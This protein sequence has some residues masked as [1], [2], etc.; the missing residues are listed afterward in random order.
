M[1]AEK[2]DKI[3]QA[4]SLLPEIP[5]SNQYRLSGAKLDKKAKLR[6]PQVGKQYGLY[7][8]LQAMYN[9]VFGQIPKY[10]LKAMQSKM[11]LTDRQKAGKK[12]GCSYP[13]A[14]QKTNVFYSG[15]IYSCTGKKTL[16]SYG[17]IEGYV[18]SAL[19][20]DVVFSVGK[21]KIE[22]IKSCQT[23]RGPCCYVDGTFERRLMPGEIYNTCLDWDNPKYR[24]QLEQDG[25]RQIIFNPFAGTHFKY[26]EP[27]TATSPFNQPFK[28]FDAF[29]AEYAVLMSQP[30]S[31]EQIN[32]GGRPYLILAKNI[33]KGD[34]AKKV[35]WNSKGTTFMRKS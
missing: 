1:D 20:S 12:R 2:Y 10:G 28:T 24:K 32:N 6:G 9:G 31:W 33:N 5:D 26:L 11:H 25:W 7:F 34:V 23:G 21:T 22:K 14:R 18:R 19:L 29:T 8:N 3:A 17:K 35:G 30:R 13:D 27:R 16:A 4:Y 15:S